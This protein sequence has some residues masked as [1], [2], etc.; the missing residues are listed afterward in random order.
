[1]A[2]ADSVVESTRE[3]DTEVPLAGQVAQTL[4]ASDPTRRVVITGIGVVSPVGNDKETAWRNLLEG[5][6]G[7]AEITRFDPSPYEHRL[8]GEVR[9][10]DPGAWM[11][12]KAARRTDRVVQFG[13]AVA[14]QALLDAGFE[15]SEENACDVGVIFGSAGGGQ[16]ILMDNVNA[17]RARGPRAVSPFFIPNSP[18]DAAAGV[19]SVETGAR[20]INISPGSACGTG[21][22]AIG[23]AASIIRRGDCT[24]IIAG[25]AENC[26]L[27][28]LH[29]GFEQ[30]RA[31]GSPRAGEPVATVSRPFDRSRNG[32]V[33]SEGAA[34]VI[35]EDLESARARG[36][37]IYAEVAGY[38]ATADAFDQVIPAPSGEGS[39]RAMQ[40]AVARAS[41]EP[42]DVGTVNAHG[43]STP[44]G[45]RRESEA[46]WSV[47][48][49]HTPEVLVTSTKSMSGHMMSACGTFEA[50]AVALSLGSGL[51]PGTLNYRDPDPECNLN[52]VAETRSANLRY[53]LS[54]SVGLGGRNSALVLKR[55]DGD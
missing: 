53:G 38:G 28:W 10:F 12:P 3:S 42:R 17:W 2:C 37:R 47:F 52:V 34:A 48:G 13:V 43:T 36:A 1:V 31:L 11:N 27:E 45:D 41:I 15:I 29:I 32:F 9:S 8:G 44:L 16:G 30:M 19:I 55:F 18:C 24:A 49:D 26:L 6:S 22:V 33:L 46:I 39:A 7:I 5:V 20:G 50:I 23:E 51:V 40:I 14:K 35:V 4:R 21:T 54:N 25:G